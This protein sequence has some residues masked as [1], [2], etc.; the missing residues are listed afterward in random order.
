LVSLLTTHPKGAHREPP[1]IIIGQAQAAPTQLPPQEA[2]FLDQLREGFPL[3]ALE[4]A[5]QHHQQH[6]EGRGGHHEREVI[7]QRERFAVHNQS[8]ELW[9]TTGVG[10][11]H[12]QRSGIEQS[13]RLPVAEAPRRPLG[14][15]P[16]DRA[17]FP[18]SS[19]SPNA[20]ALRKRSSARRST[21][22]RTAV[23]TLQTAWDCEW[24][25]PGYRVR[26]GTAP[27]GNA[28]GLHP[29]R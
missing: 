19:L 23:A 9:D 2:A 16:H 20:L 22:V 14:N 8:I 13:M 12:A 24:S 5:R 26:S 6:L 11:L 28:L 3:A 25:R 29:N 1:S 7:S 27:T 17:T 4:P 18:G 10:S 21:M 15:N